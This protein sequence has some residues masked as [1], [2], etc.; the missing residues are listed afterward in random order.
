MLLFVKLIF[1]LLFKHTEI[2]ISKGESKSC[3]NVS[4]EETNM[5]VLVSWV[6]SNDIEDHGEHDNENKEEQHENFEVTDNT[7]DHGD[8]IT[9]A[10]H[11][12]H[13][14]ESFQ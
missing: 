1:A 2:E 12:T 4:P 3:E 9:K 8:D 13:E 5:S 7:K 14:E 6:W 10:L 11:N